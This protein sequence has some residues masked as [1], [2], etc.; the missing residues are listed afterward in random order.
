MKKYAIFWNLV[1]R[2]FELVRVGTYIDL[3]FGSYVT[4]YAVDI[5]AELSIVWI[6][7]L[8]KSRLE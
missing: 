6:Q 3:P 8:L 4:N 5:P 7:F 2:Y 1:L